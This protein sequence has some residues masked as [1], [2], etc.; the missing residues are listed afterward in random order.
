[1]ISRAAA[2]KKR[3]TIS[4]SDDPEKTNTD[5]HW[6]KKAANEAKLV[7]L[8]RYSVR[9][10]L[11]DK[12]LAEEMRK[13]QDMEDCLGVTK[14]AMVI[15]DRVVAGLTIFLMGEEWF[16]EQHPPDHDTRHAQA[17]RW[18]PEHELTMIAFEKPKSQA[19]LY[20][21]LLVGIHG[22]LPDC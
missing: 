17:K 11:S 10:A 2:R 4:D 12:L 15:R 9:K 5:E 19:Y 20:W 21:A 3:Q 13:L 7:D 1:M 8:E 22:A 6:Q 18:Y 14:L 16:R